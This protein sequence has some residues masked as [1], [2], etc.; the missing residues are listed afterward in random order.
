MCWTLPRSTCHHCGSLNAL[1]QRLVVLPSLALL[2]GVP[3]FSTDDAVA[4]WDRAA[5]AG[6][7]G[8]GGGGALS[9]GTRDPPSGDPHCVPPTPPRMRAHRPAPRTRG[10]R[11]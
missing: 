2:A 10:V 7:H 11:V 5:L 4:V 8:G 9:P 6:P 3:A 1:D